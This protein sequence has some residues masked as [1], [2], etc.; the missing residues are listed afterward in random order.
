MELE[1]PLRFRRLVRQLPKGAGSQQAQ[2]CEGS[3]VLKYID[4]LR[5]CYVCMEQR[6]EQMTCRRRLYIRRPDKS[7]ASVVL[8]NRLNY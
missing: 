6:K 1:S 5:P 8:A 3:M 2:R 4:T 7:S